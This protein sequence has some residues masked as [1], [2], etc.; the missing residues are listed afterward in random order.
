MRE[1]PQSEFISP[2]Q[3]CDWTAVKAE[4]ELISRCSLKKE[5]GMERLH[6]AEGELVSLHVRSGPE[7]PAEDDDDDD[8][9][10]GGFHDCW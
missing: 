5:K 8:A 4:H 6:T 1:S 3:S 2:Q 10:H 9:A 7:E